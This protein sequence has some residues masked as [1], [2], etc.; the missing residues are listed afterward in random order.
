[1]NSINSCLP[2]LFLEARLQGWSR[3]GMP[4]FLDLDI[5]TQMIKGPLRLLRSQ[6]PLPRGAMLHCT[7][8]RHSTTGTPYYTVRRTGYFYRKNNQQHRTY[9]R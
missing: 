7:S 9:D 3:S 2:R 1:M 5:G 6:L 4:R 8:N